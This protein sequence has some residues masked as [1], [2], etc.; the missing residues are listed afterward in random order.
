MAEDKNPQDEIN[1]DIALEEALVEELDERDLEIVQLKEEAAQLKDRLLRTAAEMDNLRKR[2]ERE[3]AE[4]TLYA[5]TN[6]A[7][8]LLSV[9]DNMQRALAHKPADTAS[10]ET[11]NL[12]AGIE[13]TERE[14]LNIFQRYNIRKVETVGAKFD[15]NF[16]QALFEMPTKDHPAGTVVQEM[17]SGFAIGDRCLRPAMVGVAKA[18]G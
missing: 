4:A 16:H 8:D 18:E 2:A 9:A 6:F 3:K 17:Q 5:A 7:R 11:K 1:P 14:L 15:P 13:M 10:D 12:F